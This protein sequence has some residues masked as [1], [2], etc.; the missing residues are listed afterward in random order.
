M[1]RITRVRARLRRLSRKRKRWY[2]KFKNLPIGTPERV[3][4]KAVLKKLRGF[5]DARAAELRKLL[6]SAVDWNGHPALPSLKREVRLCLNYGCYVTSTSEGYPGDGVHTPSS[7]HY[8][9]R[10]VDLGGS[11]TDLM[12]AQNALVNKFGSAH[13]TELFGPDN[14]YV[15]NGVRIHGFMSGHSDHIHIAR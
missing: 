13:F 11:Y 1:K 4:A 2:E 9:S 6:A 14:F 15:K 12:A 7:Y 3:R 10:A 8:K 5:Y